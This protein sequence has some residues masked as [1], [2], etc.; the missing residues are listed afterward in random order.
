MKLWEAAAREEQRVAEQRAAWKE[1]PLLYTQGTHHSHRYC[2][3]IKQKPEMM[4]GYH[5]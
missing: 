2:L 3:E 5:S 4:P 1:G